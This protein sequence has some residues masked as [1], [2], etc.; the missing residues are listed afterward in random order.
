MHKV[1]VQQ[2]HKYFMNEYKF[3]YL[4]TLKCFSR[5]PESKTK[6]A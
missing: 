3:K 1:F 6:K 5:A 2:K 4:F